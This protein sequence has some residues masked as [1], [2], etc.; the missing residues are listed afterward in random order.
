MIM[1]RRCA[2]RSDRR[3]VTITLGI[4]AERDTTVRPPTLSQHET[5]AGNLPS[6][7]NISQLVAKL[8]HSE[9][10]QTQLTRLV[11]LGVSVYVLDLFKTYFRCICL[12]IL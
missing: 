5:V 8:K 6:L 12:Y 10:R 11:R 1:P 4:Q 9:T 2:C 7:L 3:A